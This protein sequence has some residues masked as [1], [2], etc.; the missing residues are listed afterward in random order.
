MMVQMYK[1]NSNCC[2]L[3]TTIRIE[4]FSSKISSYNKHWYSGDVIILFLQF[5]KN[6]FSEE[7]RVYCIFDNQW[8]K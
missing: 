3:N 8:M 7:G 1:K 4:M 5:P 2:I 6:L